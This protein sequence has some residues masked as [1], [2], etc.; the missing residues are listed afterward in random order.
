MEKDILDSESSCYD[1][2]AGFTFHNATIKIQVG[3]SPPGSKFDFVF[4]DYGC[5]TLE[6]V[7]NSGNRYESI[8]KISVKLTLDK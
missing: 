7:Q 1:G 8:E 4:A 6:F 3:S 5:G 2:D